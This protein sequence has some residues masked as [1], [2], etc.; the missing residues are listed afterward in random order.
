MGQKKQPGKS[1][2]KLYKILAVLYV[3]FYG[4]Y[5]PRNI[6]YKY[7]KLFLIYASKKNIKKKC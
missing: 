3:D 5:V 4:I 2:I 6:D 1:N 7:M